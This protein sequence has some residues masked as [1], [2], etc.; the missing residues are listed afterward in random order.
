MN[1]QLATAKLGVLLT[2]EAL[3]AGRHLLVHL[4]PRKLRVES[5]EAS[6][7]LTSSPSPCTPLSKPPFL[8]VPMK[9]GLG[10]VFESPIWY[11]AL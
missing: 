7:S 2:A 1:L 8:L 9:R 10:F 5:G 6:P 3:E 4:F 11:V